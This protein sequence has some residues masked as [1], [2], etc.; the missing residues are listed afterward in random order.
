M[1]NPSVRDRRE[2]SGNVT[3]GGTRLPRRN[4]KGGDGHSPPNGVA[5]PDSIPTSA[6]YVP[7]E[8]E[9]GDCLGHPVHFK[10]IAVVARINHCIVAIPYIDR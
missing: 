6:R 8:P 4:R 7:W 9:A 10:R 5:R 1:G 2:A 3:Y